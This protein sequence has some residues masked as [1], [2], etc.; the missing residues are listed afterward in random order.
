ML[1]RFELSDVAIRRATPADA[2]RLAWVRTASWRDAYAEIIPPRTLE[3]IATHDA[4]RMR[5]AVI[6]RRFGQTVWVVTDAANV[7][8]GYAWSGPQTDRSLPFL[9]EIYELYL[10]PAWQGRGAGRMLL[11]HAIWELVSVGQHPACL[12]VLA[13]N[14]ARHFYESCGGTPVGSRNVEL[15]GRTTKKILYG[16]HE[17]LPLPGLV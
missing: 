1:V 10:H 3:R 9:G 13:E 12:W 8:F 14:D 7:I 17:Q 2:A 4:D 15:G 11:T 5:R 16:W 6:D